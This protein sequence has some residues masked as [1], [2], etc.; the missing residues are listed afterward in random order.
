M[1][2]DCEKNRDHIAD[3]VSGFLSESQVQALEQHMSECSVCRDYAR[4]LR[5][6]DGLLSEFFAEIE[7]NMTE[8]EGHVLQA[9]NCSS[10][11]EQSD[12]LSIR[13]PTMNNLI[14]KFAAAAIILISAVLSITFF[15]RGTTPAYALEQTIKAT[16]AIRTLH[17]RIYE[18]TEGLHNDRS[19]LCWIRYNDAGVV[20]NLRWNHTEN[21]GGT[22]NIVWNEGIYKNWNPFK[23]VLIVDK[24]PELGYWTYFARDYDPKRILERLYANPEDDEAVRLIIREPVRDGDPIYVEATHIEGNYRAVLLVDPETKL[25]K[26]YSTYDLNAPED[27]QLG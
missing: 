12:K 3:L 1:N 7:T 6:E 14:T 20:S 11:P 27:D 5:Q 26:Q 8:C 17:C 22:C 15:D 18:S 19:D 2:C 25:V 10:A 4:A 24:I 23:N 13:R 16:H 9:T 21:D